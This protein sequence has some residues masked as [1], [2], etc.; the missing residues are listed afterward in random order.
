MRTAALSLALTAL[1]ALPLS[2]AAQSAAEKEVLASIE[3]FTE[4]LRR[5]DVEMMRASIEPYTRLTLLRPTPEGGLRVMVLTAD[6]FIQRVSAPDQPALDEPIRNPVVQIDADL[7]T[8]WAEYQVRIDGN[9]SHCGYD[10]F[11]LV[12][13]AGR[14]KIINVSDTFRREGCGAAWPA[15]KPGT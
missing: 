4:G 2:A 7:A 15:S 8:V 13:L 6:E 14:W 11:H 5:K 10:A 3:A 9:V 1:A 12:R